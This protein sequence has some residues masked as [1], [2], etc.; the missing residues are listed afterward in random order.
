M[1]KNDEINKISTGARL[2]MQTEEARTYKSFVYKNSKEGCIVYICLSISFSLTKLLF[3][4][5][6]GVLQVQ[7]YGRSFNKANIRGRKL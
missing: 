2:V 1:L 7:I 6:E 3:V 5:F 4:V